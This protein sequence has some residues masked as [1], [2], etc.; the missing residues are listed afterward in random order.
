MIMKTI[1]SEMKCNEFF[2]NNWRNNVYFLKESEEILFKNQKRYFFFSNIS[3]TIK[4]Q[5]TSRIEFVYEK[6]LSSNLI[7]FRI[8]YNK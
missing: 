3:I 7:A 1:Y 5:L 4:N 8:I 6:K 2:L